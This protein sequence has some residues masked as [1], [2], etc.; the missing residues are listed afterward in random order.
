MEELFAGAVIA[1]LSGSLGY[2]AAV[3]ASRSVL[4]ERRASVATVLL[5]ELSWLES[6]LREKYGNPRVAGGSSRRLTTD[7]FDRFESDF[8]LFRSPTVRILL[9]FRGLVR[10]IEI[11]ISN[12]NRSEKEP[13]DRAH[14][15]IR[16]KAGFAAR[17][18]PALRSNLEDAGGE[19]ETDVK[20][21]AVGYPD[22]PDLPPR[23]FPE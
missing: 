10:D 12:L 19:F 3:W 15:F 11:S 6:S 7:S 16:V 1:V 5:A 23:A 21:E 4:V 14:H 20:Y 8:V 22:L 17:L 13:T 18:V 2:L 9:Q